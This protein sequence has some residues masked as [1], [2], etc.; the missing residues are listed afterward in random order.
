MKRIL[1]FLLFIF[2]G[3]LVYAEFNQPLMTKN[4]QE[5]MTANDALNR[6]IEGNKRFTENKA[7]ETDF[8]G[9]AKLASGSQYPIAVVLSCIDS[10]VPPEVIF[11]QYAGN[12]FVTRIAANVLNHDVLAGME[13]STAIAGAK[14]IVV[15]G[16]DSC[17]A[18]KGACDKVTLGNL[19][20]LLN[21]I[22]PAIL[23]AQK[24]TGRKECVNPK[25][26]DLAAVDNVRRVVSLIPQES[27]VIQKLL[28][29]GKIKIVGAIYHL[30]NGKVS[31][32]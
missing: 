30:D 12:I 25:F 19:T 13:Y 29:S 31:F 15:L 14:L 23:D 28:V 8:L 24:T 17:G 6:L 20:Q 21:K 11:D 32:L 9:H 16:H 22:Q 18:V 27:P 26:I 5:K 3:S 1:F 2:Q 7:I 10:R 4:T